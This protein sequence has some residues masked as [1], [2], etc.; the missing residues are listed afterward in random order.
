VLNDSLLKL[1]EEAGLIGLS[2]K[3]SFL[4][5]KSSFCHARQSRGFNTRRE[6]GLALQR[7]PARRS[8]SNPALSPRTLELQTGHRQRHLSR[9]R[10]GG[11]G[12][13]KCRAWGPARPLSLASLPGSEGRW[14]LAPQDGLLRYRCRNHRLPKGCFALATKREAT[15]LLRFVQRPTRHCET[16]N[17][18]A[19]APF[20]GKPN[21][22]SDLP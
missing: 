19:E 22:Q 10:A 14:R 21:L 2:R 18:P 5:E 3:V 17:G 20:R 12:R 16:H 6:S 1:L 11:G 4:N 9:C 13:A 7:L 15:R 8:R